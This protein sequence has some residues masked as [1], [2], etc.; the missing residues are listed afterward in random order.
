MFLQ[1]FVIQSRQ[2]ESIIY[3]DFFFAIVVASAYSTLAGTCQA[4][5]MSAILA[6]TVAP[7]SYFAEGG[8]V[9]LQIIA[10]INVRSAL[11]PKLYSIDRGSARIVGVVAIQVVSTAFR[12]AYY[13][14]STFF[15]TIILSNAA[16][17]S[18]YL[19]QYSASKY[20]AFPQCI[21]FIQLRSST[22]IVL[23]LVVVVD[24]ALRATTNAA[25]DVA[26]LV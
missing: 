16:F 7:K 25:E 19:V 1:L 3:T 17:F 6:Y 8:F 24:V 23:Q 18:R 26:L 4:F 15:S 11:L 10:T 5:L 12:S 21:Y 9:E 2:P 22:R 14:F 13:F 20:R